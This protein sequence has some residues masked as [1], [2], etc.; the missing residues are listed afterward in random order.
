VTAAFAEVLI[1]RCIAINVNHMTHERGS[2][3]PATLQPTVSFPE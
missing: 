3:E 2:M 1:G